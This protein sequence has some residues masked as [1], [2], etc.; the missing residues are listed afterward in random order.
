M[1]ASGSSTTSPTTSEVPVVSV[2]IDQAAEVTKTKNASTCT[3]KVNG[4]I[5]NH[6]SNKPVAE[7]ESSACANMAASALVPSA[8]VT[9]LSLGNHSAKVGAPC[10]ALTVTTNN[11]VS[12]TLDDAQ[13]GHTDM[14]VNLDAVDAGTA[15]SNSNEQP[16]L[17]PA[18]ALTDDSNNVIA[19]DTASAI[20]TANS[21][22]C[23]HTVSPTCASH[24]A[25]NVSSQNVMSVGDIV[26]GSDPSSLDKA[27]KPADQ[28]VVETVGTGYISSVCPVANNLTDSLNHVPT[29]Q[30]DESKEDINGV[31]YSNAIGNGDNTM[32]ADC[33]PA[34][35]QRCTSWS[36]SVEISP[37]L[38]QHHGHEES[39]RR[40]TDGIPN[41][42]A[43][44]FSE[45]DGHTSNT[46][47]SA[48]LAHIFGRKQSIPCGHVNC[49]TTT[50]CEQCGSTVAGAN[51]AIQLPANEVTA[52]DSP[53]S[54]H[55]YSP[56]VVAS[57]LNSSMTTE[58]LASELLP[59]LT[60]CVQ[61]H[62]VIQPR[63]LYNRTM[64]CI[65]PQMSQHKQHSNGDDTVNSIVK[66]A[67][68]VKRVSNGGGPVR[69][70]S[71]LNGQVSIVNT[72]TKLH[73]QFLVLSFNITLV[74]G[75]LHIWDSFYCLLHLFSLSC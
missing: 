32:A 11:A 10:A 64:S 26:S 55:S 17:L 63:A 22:L 61:S 44:Q 13:S 46:V 8:I 33:K 53:A 67:R 23:M 65:C 71:D 6:D 52:R 48:E 25:R 68:M 35:V 50:D 69:Q 43:E 60:P 39:R 34:T 58:T 54:N 18:K 56:C 51:S 59:D 49:T 20:P 72:D 14:T 16:A 4:G 2:G 9:S 70:N 19:P 27:N 21:D 47:L 1:C 73:M 5:T 75:W 57:S 29:S 38:Q 28:V 30:S 41:N 15:V 31:T 3:R 12:A 7:G 24:S 36:P 40:T 45:A 42:L 62:G 37:R 66:I 74:L